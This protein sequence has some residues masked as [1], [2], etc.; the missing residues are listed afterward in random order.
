MIALLCLV[1]LQ[2]TAQKQKADS[3][4]VLLAKQHSD[5][6]R[7]ECMWKMA[8]YLY[9]YAPDSSLRVAQKALFLAQRI[10][11]AEGESRS[12]GQM[13]NGFL[14]MGNYSKALEFYLR[15]LRLEEKGKSSYNL[16]SVIMNIGIVYAYR[17]EYDLSLNYLRQADSIIETEQLTDLRFNINLN[18]GDVYYRKDN[19]DSAYAYFDRSLQQAQ[20][21][22]DVDFTGTAMVG[23]G[24][25]Y[26]KAQ[27]YDL[28][29]KIYKAAIVFLFAA[30][31][32]DFVCEAYLGLA[33]LYKATQQPDS[34]LHY[35]KAS[36]T[37]ARKDLFQ[38]RELEAV[39]FLTEVYNEQNKKDSAFLYLQKEKLLSDDI[40]SKEKIRESES[41]TINEKLRQDEMA[42]AE[43]RHKDER[44]QQLQLLLIGLAIPTLFLFTVL[45]SRIKLP[46]RIIRFLGIISL[47]ILFEYLTLLLHPLVEAFTHHTPIYELLI[48]VVIASMLI[49]A[50][51]RIE[52]WLIHKLTLPRAS[53]GKKGLNPRKEPA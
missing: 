16:A 12:L 31:D 4:Q 24:N 49:P 36:Y 37:L 25:T 32:E 48:F 23:L 45:L 52:H 38:S 46:A 19:T 2:A 3:M 51:H 8:S 18:L 53:K 27:R 44:R 42:E 7:V 6:G 40:Y 5:T 34:S 15:K 41:I 43:R 17:E 14:S 26:L 35:A 20:E 33:K 9:S 21:M 39:M 28:A 30:N 10:K 1:S 50:H 22:K 11:Y 13:A 47:L 29:L